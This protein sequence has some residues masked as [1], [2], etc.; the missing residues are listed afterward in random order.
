MKDGLKTMKDN[1]VDSRKW[2]NEPDIFNHELNHN[3]KEFVKMMIGDTSTKDLEERLRNLEIQEGI[4]I[5]KIET[6]K[7]LLKDIQ[8]KKEETIQEIT[9]RKRIKQVQLIGK[10]KPIPLEIVNNTR[11]IKHTDLRT[12]LE[13]NMYK[14]KFSELNEDEI[15]EG[16]VDIYSIT[17]PNSIHFKFKEQYSFIIIEK[18]QFGIF[19][20][21]IKSR[22]LSF[23]GKTI[24]L[25]H[26]FVDMESVICIY[27]YKPSAEVC[28]ELEFVGT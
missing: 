27:V 10:I 28:P 18:A 24:E 13:K 8:S 25:D 7:D 12:E 20:R 3:V 26:A 16:K 4:T 14:A 22:C 17:D 21:D 9:K 6:R 23:N 1:H 11:G 15:T 5:E 19:S 2:Y